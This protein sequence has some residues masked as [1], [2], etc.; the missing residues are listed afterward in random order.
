[1]KY[2][3]TTVRFELQRR[4]HYVTNTTPEEWQWVRDCVALTKSLTAARRARRDARRD[5]PNAE[6]RIVRVMTTRE[7][8]R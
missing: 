7:V 8:V 3:R 4:I 2:P 1:M 6:F 5:E